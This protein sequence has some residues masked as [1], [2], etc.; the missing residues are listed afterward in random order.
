M[1]RE[2]GLATLNPPMDD[3]FARVRT[4][5]LE[6]VID[7]KNISHMFVSTSPRCQQT[8]K[9]LLRYLRTINRTPD[10]RF[11]PALREV[12]FDLDIL[13]AN[14]HLEKEMLEFGIVPVNTAVFEGMISGIGCESISEVH[15]RVDSLFKSLPPSGNILLITHDFLMR[16]TELYIKGIS[17]IDVNALEQ[18]RRN[19]YMTGFATD[20]K[21][22]AFRP[23]D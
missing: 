1:L 6:H 20:E 3:F 23:I 16:V 14:N 17:H 5:E 12:H 7:M 2:L 15:E 8:A 9:V 22:L 4:K 13:N 18:T 11:T 21:L 10:A 19:G